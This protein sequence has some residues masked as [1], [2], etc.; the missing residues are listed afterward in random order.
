M[1]GGNNFWYHITATD[2]YHSIADTN[3]LFGNF[4]KIVKCGTSNHRTLNFHRL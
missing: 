3:I 2:Y 4:T 1:N